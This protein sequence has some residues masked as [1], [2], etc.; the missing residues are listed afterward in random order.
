MFECLVSRVTFVPIG[1]FTFTFL[2]N[3]SN[4][5][6]RRNLQALEKS[7]S[8]FIQLR[9]SEA[10]R[11]VKGVCMSFIMSNISKGTAF[12]KVL[13]IVSIRS[14][15]KRTDIV[16]HCYFSRN[17]GNTRL[18]MQVLCQRLSPYDRHAHR[19]SFPAVLA[20]LLGKRFQIPTD[21]WQLLALPMPGRRQNLSIYID[22][23]FIFS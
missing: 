3:E 9:K 22:F 1:K 14:R 7:N 16:F 8:F 5:T 15:L 20:L 21:C 23:H 2:I 12:L 6:G 18:I 10:D 11:K 13:Q 4:G 17:N 19:A